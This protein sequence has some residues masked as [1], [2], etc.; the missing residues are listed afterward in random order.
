MR[1]TVLLPFGHYN[2][3]NRSFSFN[4]AAT[5]CQFSATVH[6]LN[7]LLFVVD[8]IG[9]IISMQSLAKSSCEI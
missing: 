8:L 6:S 9:K 4:L 2:F 3:L 1:F 7:Y 5:F